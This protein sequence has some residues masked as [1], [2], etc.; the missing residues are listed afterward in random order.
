MTMSSGTVVCENCGSENLNF[1]EQTDVKI[2]CLDCDH[3]SD[4]AY[5]ED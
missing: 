5:V 2:T 3:V 4:M 1:G